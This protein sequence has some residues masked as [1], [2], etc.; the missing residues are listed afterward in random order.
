VSGL[1]INH[2]S[3][4]NMLLGVWQVAA[5][6]SVTSRGSYPKRAS[7]RQLHDNKFEGIVYDSGNGTQ[8]ASRA[9]AAEN[10]R[11]FCF[12]ICEEAGSEI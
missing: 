7:V 8:S 6:S 10:T 5:R 9:A 11:V 3:T 4:E 2:I 1:R 12:V